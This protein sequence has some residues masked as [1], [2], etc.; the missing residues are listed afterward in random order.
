MGELGIGL[1]I[2]SINGQLRVKGAELRSKSDQLLAFVTQEAGDANASAEGAASAAQRANDEAEKAKTAASDATT[3]AQTAHTEAN[4]VHQEIGKATEQLR[5]IEGKA[6]KTKD[7]LTNLALCNAPRVISDWFLSGNSG[8]KTYLDPLLPM[9]GQMV[10][11]EHVPDA[12]AR[13]AA[14]SIAR[15]LTMAQWKV[16]KPLKVVDGIAD[17]VSVQ[18]SLP[19]LGLAKGQTP[20]MYPYWHAGD[21]AE[22]LLEYLHSYNWQAE[23]GFPLDADRELI[24]DENVLPAG[25]IR[26][27]VGLYPPAVY[28]SQPGQ[29]ELM[30]EM[31]RSEE[32]ADAERK[33]RRQEQL[34]K[35]P[36]ELRKRIEQANEEYDA[37]IK[38]ETSKGPCQPLNF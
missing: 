20:N 15:T 9:A 5:Q 7:D 36:P 38:S 30:E 37:K 1:T 16:Q 12:E 33:R 14:N 22:T 26:I 4:S 6:Q 28:V 35:L 34:A 27:Q 29:K 18:P 25:A 10:L 19:I 11:I 2:S 31:K 13:R 17:G 3:L 23:R 32:K 24:R 8:F 21:A